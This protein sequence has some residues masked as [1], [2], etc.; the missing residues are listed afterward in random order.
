MAELID[1]AAAPAVAVAPG[2][3]RAVL[4]DGTRCRSTEFTAELFRMAGPV[5]A[6]METPSGSDQYLFVLAGVVRLATEAL[7]VTL[8]PQTFVSVPEGQRFS[9]HAAVGVA[10]TVLSVVAPPPG[11]RRTTQGSGRRMIVSHISHLP[12]LD[13]PANKKRRVY[14]ATAD[15]TGT[16]RAHGMV[17]FYEGE[18]V[19]PVHRHPDAESLF[20]F[21]DD[22]ALV[23]VNDREVRVDGGQAVFWGLGEDHGLRSA[24]ARGLSFLEFH[25]PGMYGVVRRPERA[26]ESKVVVS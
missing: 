10:V 18:T 2:V 19:T 9:L 7:D 14:L 3:E 15:T 26:T 20:V 24:T 25:I 23:L 16:K 6:R 1:L 21:L 13:E 17:V 5:E 4:V 8:T 11:A 12:V 22:P